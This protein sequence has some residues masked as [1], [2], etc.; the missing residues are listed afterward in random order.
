MTSG[1]WKFPSNQPYVVQGPRFS[2][3][4]AERATIMVAGPASDWHLLC[5]I[6]FRRNGSLFVQFPYFSESAG[7]LADVRFAVSSEGASVMRLED[8]GRATTHLVKYHHPPDGNAHFSQD[9]KIV[10][11]IRRKSFPLT[12]PGLLWELHAFGLY[13][14]E[15]ASKQRV[16]KDRAYIPAVFTD[17]L[18]DRLVLSGDW[19]LRATVEETLIDGPGPTVTIPGRRNA[20]IK[21]TLL[22]PPAGFSL[23]SYVL[24]LNMG[25]P[26]PVESVDR[27]TMIFMGGWDSPAAANTNPG[28]GCLS[29]MYPVL[30]AEELA[31]RIGTVDRTA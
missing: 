30:D 3:F 2:Y 28:T 10:S 21:A 20:S 14:F 16:R 8:T 29:F 17:G 11:T 15:A 9:D 12:N 1:S 19:R 24:A 13:G 4:A 22:G 18:P 7:I 26:P 23:D 31:A 6:Q 27:P 25:I 5:Q